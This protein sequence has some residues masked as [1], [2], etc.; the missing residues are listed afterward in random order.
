MSEISDPSSAPTN[1]PDGN[2]LSRIVVIMAI[3]LVAAVIASLVYFSWR[4]TAGLAIGGALS[5]LNFYWLKASLG[6]MLSVAASG[7]AEPMSFWLLKYN[8][9]FTSLVLVILAVYMLGTV[10]LIALFCGLLSLAAAITAEGFIQLFLVV[11]KRKG[12]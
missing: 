1:D 12:S 10:S 5:F 3:L 9:R 6:K 2:I 8:L 11:F 4:E 7:T